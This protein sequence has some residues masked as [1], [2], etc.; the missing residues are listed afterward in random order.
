MDDLMR[1]P[2]QQPLPAS[3]PILRRSG[4]AARGPPPGTAGP[5]AAR[6]A[7]ALPSAPRAATAPCGRGAPAAA[8]AVAA[9]PASP[10][11]PGGGASGSPGRRQEPE[12]PRREWRGAPLHEPDGQRGGEVRAASASYRAAAVVV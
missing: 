8:G 6:P 7:A 5:G 12:R 9:A 2:Q 10:G 4:R 1:H 3:R 11:A